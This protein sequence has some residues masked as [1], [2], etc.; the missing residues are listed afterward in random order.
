MGP[1]L[2]GEP[3]D[4]AAESNSDLLRHYLEKRANLVRFFAARL[5]SATAAEDLA[6]DLYLKVAALP[7]AEVIQ[8]PTALLYRMGSNLMLDRLRQERRTVVRDSAWRRSAT[9]QLGDEEIQDEPPADEALAARQRLA[10]LLRELESLPPRMRRAFQL[11]KLEGLSHLETAR[12]MGISVSAV[13]KHVSG[14]LKAL[15]SRLS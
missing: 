5:G 3:Q 9:T 2:A 4:R 8:N 12:A 7:V 14:A 15:L 11:H 6:Q 1:K 10:L 13:E